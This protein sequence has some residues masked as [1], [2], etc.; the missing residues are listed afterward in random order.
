MTRAG[1]TLASFACTFSTPF[2]SSS[3][4]RTSSCALLRSNTENS[5]D[6]DLSSSAVENFFA[7]PGLLTA[8]PGRVDAVLGRVAAAEAAVPG[9]RGVVE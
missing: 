4:R 9:Q 8:D 2:T 5:P 7:V 3:N 1:L 6:A